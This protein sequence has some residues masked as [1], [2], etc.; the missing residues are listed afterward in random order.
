M[1]DTPTADE[2]L[3]TREVADLLRVASSTVIRWA[4]T[5]FLPGIRAG[6]DWRFRRADVE[7][8]LTPVT[9]DEATA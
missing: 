6:R 9:P 3:T 8:L 7:Q 5:G 2:L 1:V 4:R